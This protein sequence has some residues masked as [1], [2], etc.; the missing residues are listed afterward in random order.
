MKTRF[1]KLT[2]GL[3]CFFAASVS[4]AALIVTLNGQ[5]V[6]STI[7][8]ITWLRDANASGLAVWNSQVTWASGLNVEGVSGWHLASQNELGNLVQ[9]EGVLAGSP[10]PFLDVQAEEY[11]TSTSISFGLEAIVIDMF[12][13]NSLSDLKLLD[14]NYAMAAIAGDVGGALN[15]VPVPAAMWLF[16]SGLLGMLALARRKSH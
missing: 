16:G 7:F 13:G 8:D 15:A 14:Q 1:I 3:L 12:D 11:W 2:L 10:F 6:Y 4:N 9:N 5:A